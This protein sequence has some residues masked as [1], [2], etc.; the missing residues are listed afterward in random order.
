MP[1]LAELTE[2]KR[3]LRKVLGNADELAALG[4]D[5]WT[6]APANVPFAWFDDPA[7]IPDGW[8]ILS[9]A[10]GKYIIGSS[11]AAGT[12]VGGQA[13]AIG[14]HSNHVVTQPSDH[15][16]SGNT[17]AE[18][19]GQAVQSGSGVTVADAPHTHGFSFIDTHSGAAVDAHSAH[20]VT[21]DF[22]PPSISFIWI[23]KVVS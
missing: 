7:N 11:T 9:D 3:N 17:G 19:A 5:F 21:Q 12:L 16:V 15:N 1:S 2:F 13:T 22:V 4:I 8:E 18:S 20:S 6:L 23:M 10:D 14:N